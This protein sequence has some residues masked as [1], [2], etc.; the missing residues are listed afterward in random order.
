MDLNAL[1]LRFEPRNG[2]L[3]LLAEILTT[4]TGVQNL[5]SL[6]IGQVEDHLQDRISYYEKQETADL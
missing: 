3:P 1:L 5:G 4:D 2:K 6:F